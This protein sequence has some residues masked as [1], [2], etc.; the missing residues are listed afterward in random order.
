MDNE[1]ATSK[2]A[3]TTSARAGKGKKAKSAVK[4]V[5]QKA[6]SSKTRKN[7]KKSTTT[8]SITQQQRQ[9]MIQDMA[10]LLAERRG[11]CNGDPR[12]DWLA[13]ESQ[14]DAQL[15]AGATHG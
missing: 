1:T 4:S 10:Y 12:E 9:L 13:A 5:T 11:F 7:T 3:K 6:T 8:V 2:T 15:L 14:V